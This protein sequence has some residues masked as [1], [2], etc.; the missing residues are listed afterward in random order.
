MTPVA[1]VC[2]EE[3]RPEKVCPCEIRL[4]KVRPGQ[5]RVPEVRPAEVRSEEVRI[6]EVR[7][8]IGVF[9]TPLVPGGHTLLQQCDV[10]VVRHESTPSLQRKRCYLCGQLLRHGDSERSR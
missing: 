9:V 5:V 1:E 10:L 7:A 3:V 6:G 4:D 8:D 2:P